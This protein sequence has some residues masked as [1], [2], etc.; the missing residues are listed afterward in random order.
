M[1]LRVMVDLECVVVVVVLCMVVVYILLWCWGFIGIE[2]LSVRIE[3]GEDGGCGL[4]CCGMLIVGIIIIS[5]E[6]CC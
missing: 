5:S 1:I 3:V 4:F 6:G 2:V